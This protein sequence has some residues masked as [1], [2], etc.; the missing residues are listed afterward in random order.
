MIRRPENPIFP[1]GRSKYHLK[2]IFL[3]KNGYSRYN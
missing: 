2:S 3:E 1:G